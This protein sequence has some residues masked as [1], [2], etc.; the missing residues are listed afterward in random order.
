MVTNKTN[1]NL[2]KT[3]RKINFIQNFINAIKILDKFWAFIYTNIA[4]NK[5]LTAIGQRRVEC[6]EH[7]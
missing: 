2:A 7:S 1:L 3:S 5:R 6:N 4:F